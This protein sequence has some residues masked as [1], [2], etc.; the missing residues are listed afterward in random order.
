MEPA[1]RRTVEQIV[2][3]PT[4]MPVNAGVPGTVPRIALPDPPA[5]ARVVPATGVAPHPL[6]PSSSR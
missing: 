6:V 2:G 3:K 5:T 4:T 1:V